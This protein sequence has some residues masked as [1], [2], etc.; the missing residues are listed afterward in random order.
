MTMA[1]YHQCWIVAYTPN[2][3]YTFV[4]TDG[5]PWDYKHWAHKQPDHKGKDNCAIVNGH[6][7]CSSQLALSCGPT[8][9]K[10]EMPVTAMC[11]QA[12]NT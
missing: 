11:Y 9:C 1:N 8:E 5:T 10:P 12:Y 2:K 3:D 6:I 7:T 4:W